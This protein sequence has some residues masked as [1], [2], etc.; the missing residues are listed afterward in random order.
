[1]LP[2]FKLKLKKFKNYICNM[3]LP[4]LYIETTANKGRA[5]FTAEDLPADTIIEVAPVIAMSAKE[6]TILDTTLLHDYIFEWGNDFTKCC[7]ALGY[8][9][10][11]NHS[12]NS[13]CT[14]FMDFEAQTIMIKT[15]TS[16]KAGEE[17]TINYNGD[18]AEE[19]KVWF[20]AV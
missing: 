19:N 1:M 8:V 7:V 2:S 10:I 18:N 14:Y 9:S 6:R 3:I 20:D 5:V 4:C 13:N 12:N 17:V 15:V 11:Y 16:I